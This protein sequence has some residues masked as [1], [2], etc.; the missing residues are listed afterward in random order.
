MDV[1]ELA[2][3]VERLSR[4]VEQIRVHLGLEPPRLVP[5]DHGTP[6]KPNAI[7]LHKVPDIVNSRASF[8]LEGPDINVVGQLDKELVS[9]RDA[10]ILVGLVYRDQSIGRQHTLQAATHLPC[11]LKTSD[12]TLAQF[13]TPLS[14]PE[15]WKLLRALLE[16]DKTATELGQATGM[17]TGQL[18]HHLRELITQRYVKQVD[19]KYTLTEIGLSMFLTTAFLVGLLTEATK[20]TPTDGATI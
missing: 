19:K 13:T 17:Q 4:Q 18:Y 11:M 5:A 2:Q 1:A 16:S 9:G 20:R 12:E 14:S 6:G 8:T 15:R 7:L 3:A 10:V